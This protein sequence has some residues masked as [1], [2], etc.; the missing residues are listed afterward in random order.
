MAELIAPPGIEAAMYVV[1]TTPA[2]RARA[3]LFSIAM[4]ACLG[5]ALVTGIGG[6]RVIGASEA[7]TLFD[8]SPPAPEVPPPP[9]VIPPKSA[10]KR[11]EGAASPPNLRSQASEIVA[12]APVFPQPPPPVLA[13]TLAGT[14]VAATQGAAPVAGPG[15]GAG[16]IG[17]GTGSG[18]AGDGDGGGGGEPP[19][20][21][22]GRLKDSDYPRAAGA[23][24]VGGT[25][26]VRYFVGEDGRVG[27]CRVTRSSGNAELDAVT[28]RLIQERFRFRPSRDEDGR[29]VGAFLVEKHS[30]I[31]HD[32]QREEP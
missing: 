32:E 6:S 2:E 1:R 27:E 5:F 29:A 11:P 25:V 7:L 16:G 26:G 4:A 8:V 3:G 15:T 31:V 28:C 19:R 21:I 23:A 17:N 18:G 22:R 24:G 14:G 30:W 9:P 10:D 12:P 20:L 13:A